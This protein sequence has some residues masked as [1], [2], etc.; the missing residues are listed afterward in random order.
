[1]C[2]HC[3]FAFYVS[4]SWG[5][6]E[7]TFDLLWCVRYMLL[8]STPCLMLTQCCFWASSLRTLPIVINSSR[9]VSLGVMEEP[10]YQTQSQAVEGNS[11]EIQQPSNPLKPRKFGPVC[12]QTHDEETT[13]EAFQP[14]QTLLLVKTIALV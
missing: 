14:G 11:L 5:S 10:A 9:F 13:R 6:T 7:R 1:M 12:R 2:L 4:E 3:A 8:I